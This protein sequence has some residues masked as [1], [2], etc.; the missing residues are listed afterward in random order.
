MRPRIRLQATEPGKLEALRVLAL[1]L[2]MLRARPE[3]SIGRHADLQGSE[4]LPPA[5]LVVLVGDTLPVETIRAARAAGA[6]VIWA[7]A[8]A[9]PRLDRRG[10]MPGRLR[11]QLLRLDRIL[12]RDA[13]AAEAMSRLVR[14]EVPVE[15]SGPLARIAPAPP[16][17]EAELAALRKAVGARPVWF[18]F[19]L[20]DAEIAAALEAHVMAM[21]QA[22]RLLI[23]AAPRDPHD[24]AELTAAAGAMGL[25]MARRLDDDD[26]D[27][28]VQVY[29]A[30]TE[31]APGLFLRLASV[32]YLGGTLTPGLPVPPVAEA[33]SLG[34][35][36]L[37]GPERDD[38]L[39][40]Q[41]QDCGGGRGLLRSAELGAALSE[42][43]APD[44]SA[45]MALQAWDF[46]TK[47]SE[48]TLQLV[49]IVEDWLNNVGS[50]QT[51]A[52]DGLR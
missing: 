50:A 24:S 19:S 16:C 15:L 49:R 48:T 17:N 30:D 14:G 4:V 1:Q 29:I 18:A 23:I 38:E 40:G 41:L 20:P 13:V 12:A 27:E 44:T 35:A 10:L 3:I 32:T 26:I 51:P 5:D 21:R 42:L 39:V 46:T 47:G 2:E 9:E 28:T 25:T 22:H 7:E 52:A 37:F 45:R 31:D 36:L 34:T 43:L 11:Q 8:G 33:A 6:G